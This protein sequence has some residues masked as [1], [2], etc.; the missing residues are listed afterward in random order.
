MADSHH[1]AFQ[2]LYELTQ[3][4]FLKQIIQYS[5][6]MASTPKPVPRLFCVDYVYQREKL[7]L[8]IRP[9]CEFDE[10]WHVTES[11]LP[12]EN[13]TLIGSYSAYLA[14]LI[15]ILKNGNQASHQLIF[16]T[17]DGQKLV[18][19]IESRVKVVDEGSTEHDS[20]FS[21][22]EELRRKFATDYMNNKLC[23][24]NESINGLHNSL[25]RCELKSGKTLWLCAEHMRVTN[26]RA[27]AYDD[28]KAN[29]ADEF[30]RL[31]LNMLEFLRSKEIEE[32]NI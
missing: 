23:S 20:I 5:E 14:R 2:E 13:K 4:R 9:M 1:A 28:S 25:K 15:N 32:I 7:A 11:Y 6:K 29:L 27:L 12:L 18:Q 22:Y 24:T 31:T 26:A 30:D 10:G 3:R 21:S 16:S 8:C 19:Q 17:S